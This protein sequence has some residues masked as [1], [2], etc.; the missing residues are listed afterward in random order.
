MSLGSSA[1]D[2]EGVAVCF[3]AFRA[4]LPE[5]TAEVTSIISDLYAISASLSNLED[6]DR[7]LR[8]RRNF[9]LYSDPLSLT[10][11]SLKY[12]LDDIL[13]FLHNLDYDDSPTA[14]K[15]VWVGLKDHFWVEAQAP[16]A[17]RL[18]KYKTILREIGD[19]VKEDMPDPHSL[20]GASTSLKNLFNAQ[21][22]DVRERVNRVPLRRNPSF[23]GSAE[24]VSPGS[25]RR[26]GRPRRTSSYERVRP[27]HMSPRSPTSPSTGTFSDFL[28]SVP[29]VPPS[30]MTS[31]TSGTTGTSRSAN[32]DSLRNHW[33]KEV[34]RLYTS[35]P[36]PTTS[37]R[38]NCQGEPYPDAKETLL[39]RGFEELSV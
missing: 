13:A 7:D 37:R 39:G 14:Y 17:T 11:A 29:D 20:S 18:V 33:A 34:F 25:D 16:L 28:P 15:R 4:P 22:V 5:H 12:T 23:S 38:S 27:A 8:Y 1:N 2:A 19:L 32:T 35:H 6:L 10:L 24:P 21:V 3:H 31:T 30:P 9:R 36:L 26:P